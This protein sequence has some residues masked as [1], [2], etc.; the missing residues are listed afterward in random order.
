[1]FTEEPKELVVDDLGRAVFGGV[2]DPKRQTSPAK[3]PLTADQTKLKTDLAAKRQA[4]GAP[5]PKGMQQPPPLPKKGPPKVGKGG[6]TAGH[7]MLGGGLIAAPVLGGL[8]MQ[9]G[10]NQQQGAYR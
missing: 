8:A 3:K 7:A 6:I 1:M 2:F 4:A 10:G 5:M 9:G